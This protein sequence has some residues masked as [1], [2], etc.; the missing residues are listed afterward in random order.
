MLCYFC[1]GPHMIRD[2]YNKEEFISLGWIVIENGLIKLGNGSWIPRHPE[3][4]SRMLR[5]EEYYR[6]QGVTKESAKQKR[7][8]MMQTFHQGGITSVS[9]YY[10][11]DMDRIDHI[12]D[13]R[14]DEIRSA[15]VQQ[16]LGRQNV[17]QQS[18]QAP[19]TQFAQ[20]IQPQMFSQAQAIAPTVPGQGIEISQ[21]IQLFNAARGGNPMNELNIQDQMVATRTGARTDPPANPKF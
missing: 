13:T 16:M 18:Y 12:Y 21:L 1:N 6:K 15:N 14:E 10:S 8:S 7:A 4:L 9:E 17:P 2:C 20:A 5:V 11:P 3:H 19:S